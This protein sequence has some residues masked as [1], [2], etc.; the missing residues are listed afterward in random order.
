[1]TLREVIAS[2]KVISSLLWPIPYLTGP[3][4]S[5]CAVSLCTLKL[6]RFL[7]ENPHFNSS[8]C[9]N[10][11]EQLSNSCNFR[12]WSSARGRRCLGIT[13][14]SWNFLR[15]VE[16]RYQILCRQ[17]RQVLI[18]DTIGCWTRDVLH[19]HGVGFPLLIKLKNMIL[20]KNFSIMQTKVYFLSHSKSPAS[21][22]TPTPMYSHAHIC[23]HFLYPSYVNTSFHLPYGAYSDIWAKVQVGNAP[24]TEAISVY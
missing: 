16:L 3:L 10:L 18:V 5:A 9:F 4:C 6:K 2:I 21:T 8:Q 14:I 15:S 12:Y 13:G 11:K 20:T 17:I 23:A 1:M 24:R 22:T 19:G 7:Q